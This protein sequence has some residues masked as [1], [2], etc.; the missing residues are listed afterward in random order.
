MQKISSG[1]QKKTIDLEFVVPFPC[2]VLSVLVCDYCRCGII[3]A[4]ANLRMIPQLPASLVSH[5][6]TAP[7]EVN[8][9]SK[10]GDGCY[11]VFLDVGSN[12]G[13][14]GRFLF[15]PQKYPDSTSSVATFDR[16]FGSPRDNRCIVS[17]HSNQIQSSNSDI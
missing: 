9:R 16:E 3:F 6:I 11:H 17:L 5:S 10:L 14:H 7:V 8:R 13:I 2:P 1:A 15:E 4:I 12:I